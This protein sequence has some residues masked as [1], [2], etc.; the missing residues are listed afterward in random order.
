M[1]NWNSFSVKE[2]SFGAETNFARGEFLSCGAK[3]REKEEGRDGTERREEAWERR[4][5]KEQDEEKHQ[6]EKQTKDKR[7]Q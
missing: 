5:I 1:K 2:K 6:E 4:E 7:K 3:Q